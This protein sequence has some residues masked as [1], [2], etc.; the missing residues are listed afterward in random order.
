[1]KLDEI[2][3]A[4]IFSDKMTITKSQLHKQ[5]ACSH[6]SLE[7]C[8]YINSNEKGY[9]KHRRSKELPTNYCSVCNLQTF[10]KIMMNRIS[11]R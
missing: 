4:D 1:M 10:T 7:E 5:Q 9:I 8:H 6:Y 2:Y 3:T 11:S